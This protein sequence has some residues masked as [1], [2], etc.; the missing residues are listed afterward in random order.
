MN[1]QT[2]PDSEPTLPPKRGVSVK[3]FP[4]SRIVVQHSP[5]GRNDEPPTDMDTKIQRSRSPP[6]RPLGAKP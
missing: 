4:V 6:S 2:V 3:R 1:N 5:S